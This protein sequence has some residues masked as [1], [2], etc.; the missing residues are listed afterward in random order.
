MQSP[1]F[2]GRVVSTVNG[3]LDIAAGLFQNL[4]HFAGHVRGE[5]F[6]VANQDL[7]QAKQKF[8]AA[9]RGCAPPAI[10]SFARGIHRIVNVLSGRERKPPHDVPGIGG[11]DV[12]NPLSAGAWHP[13][14]ANVVVIGLNGNASLILRRALRAFFGENFFRLSHTRVSSLEFQ[15]SSCWL[16]RNSELETRNFLL[17]GELHDLLGDSFRRRLM[18]RKIQDDGVARL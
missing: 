5:C 15:V 12:F 10:E 2:A 8:G 3:F 13:S 18:I 9:R 7:A 6:F 17:I 1:A 14:P 11:I 4:A 16:T